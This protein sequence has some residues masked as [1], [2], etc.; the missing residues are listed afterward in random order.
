MSTTTIVVIVARVVRGKLGNV[1]WRIVRGGRAGN[2]H[3]DDAMMC[4]GG[5][6]GGSVFAPVGGGGCFGFSG[7]GVFHY[8][9]L[10]V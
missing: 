5:L 1:G 10:L 2:I 6:F 8:V 4:V 7:I 3:I 9:L